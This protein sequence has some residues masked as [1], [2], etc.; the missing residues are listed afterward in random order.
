MKLKIKLR[1][2]LLRFYKRYDERPKQL[3]LSIEELNNS[4]GD[5]TIVWVPSI[6]VNSLTEDTTFNISINS[7]GVEGE[8]KNYVYEVVLF[9]PTN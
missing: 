3:G 6:D 1:P 7:V 4:F 2:K 8:Q 9:D 5:R